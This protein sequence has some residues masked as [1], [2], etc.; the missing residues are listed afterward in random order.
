MKKLATILALTGVVANLGFATTFAEVSTGSQTIECNSFGNYSLIAPADLGFYQRTTNFY[1]ETSA[2]LETSV[3]PGAPILVVTDT[4][5]YDSTAADCGAG[6]TLSVQSN[7][8][9]FGDYNINLGTGSFNNTDLSEDVGGITE[10]S[11]E[12]LIGAAALVNTISESTNQPIETSVTLMTSSEAFYGDV[13]FALNT[14]NAD[15]QNST[16]LKALH[17]KL[18]DVNGAYVGPIPAGDYTGDITFTLA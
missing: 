18:E 8:L 1:N 14:G 7:G 11:P 6:F 16:V 10:S 9:A 13:T 17:D 4:R 12:T 15:N 5:G 2:P 3:G